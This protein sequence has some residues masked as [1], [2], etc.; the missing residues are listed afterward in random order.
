M[1]TKASIQNPI[2]AVSMAG[3]FLLMVLF[4]S[5]CG[6]G[7]GGD[8]SS[9]PPDYAKKLAGSPPELAALHKQADDLLPGG[10]DA[11]NKKIESL[12]GFPVVVNIWGS[13]CGPCRAEFPHF[14]EASANKGKKVAFLGVNSDDS[15]DAAKTFLEEDPLS[16]PS[17][18]DPDESLAHDLGANYGLPAT[19]FFDSEGNK[20]YTKSGQY[21]ST[22]DLESDIQHFAVEGNKD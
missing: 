3:I 1:R 18:T 2:L 14:Q 10:S 13:W 9:P 11:F 22:A 15:D 19:A 6:A 16:Y 12:K 21:T 17:F 20:T 4:L 8:T 5:A 7:S